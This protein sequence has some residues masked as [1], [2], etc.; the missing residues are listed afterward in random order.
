MYKNRNTLGRYIRA[1]R[2]VAPH[3]PPPPA[4][5]LFLPLPRSRMHCKYATPLSPPRHP[6]LHNDSNSSSHFC[7]TI[8]FSLYCQSTSSNAAVYIGCHR[9]HRQLLV[10][11][12]ALMQA[13]E[14]TSGST[15]MVAGESA[16]MHPSSPQRQGW[17]SWC[18]HW[19]Y[20]QLVEACLLSRDVYEC[21][22]CF[23]RTL[24]C[25]AGCGAFSRG[26]DAW[27]EERC[28]A[29]QGRVRLQL[30]SHTENIE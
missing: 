8:G 9:I 15:A 18:C 27:D 24:P 13:L 25:R 23:R 19:Q 5:S 7:T 11:L 4:F 12:Q 28:A 3:P 6:G 17:C 29:C 26:F 14:L 30:R 16:D 20:H 22:G 10:T 21:Q 1:V 2:D